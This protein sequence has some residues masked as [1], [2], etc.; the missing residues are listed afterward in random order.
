ML[1][2]TTRLLAPFSA[3]LMIHA[4]TASPATHLD[5]AVK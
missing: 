5:K 3:V 2:P 1:F 4:A